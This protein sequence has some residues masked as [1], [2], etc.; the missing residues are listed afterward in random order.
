MVCRA[1]RR[2]PRLPYYSPVFSDRPL[3]LSHPPSLPLSLR[4]CWLMGPSCSV[5]LTCMWP[6]PPPHSRPPASSSSIEHYRT[7]GISQSQSQIHNTSRPQV[8]RHHLGP[9][10]DLYERLGPAKGE[11]AR[12][13]CAGAASST[14][15]QCFTVPLDIIGQVCIVHVTY[16]TAREILE[17]GGGGGQHYR[18]KREK[19]GVTVDVVVRRAVILRSMLCNGQEEE[20]ETTDSR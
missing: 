20:R 2:R 15:M 1:D 3:A 16:D 5:S 4:P 6:L 13:M 19:G 11:L 9:G 18:G 17:G 8:V 12:N 7:V 10:S 14:V